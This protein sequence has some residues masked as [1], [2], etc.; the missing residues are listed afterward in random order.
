MLTESRNV[1]LESG[2]CWKDS[3]TRDDQYLVLVGIGPYLGGLYGRPG[4]RAVSSVVCYHTLT[5]P[6]VHVVAVLDVHVHSCRC[7]LVAVTVAQ[8]VPFY[9]RTPEIYSQ[10]YISLQF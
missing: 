7:D 5:R 8:E 6:R 10:G 3:V 9:F 4:F 2:G 1:L